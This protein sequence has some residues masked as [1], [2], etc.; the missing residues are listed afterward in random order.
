M[1]N[2]CFSNAVFC[3]CLSM[4]VLV[5]STGAHAAEITKAKGKSVLIKFDPAAEQL[6]V[7]EKHFALVDGKKKALIEITQ[8]KAGQALGKIL[9]GNAEASATLQLAAGAAAGETNSQRP[10]R[11]SR[12]SESPWSGISFGVL[13]GAGMDSQTVKVARTPTTSENVSLSGTG[14]GARLFADLPLMNQIGLFGRLGVEKFGGTGKSNIGS[15]KVDFTFLA[16][17]GLI[18]FDFMTGDWVPFAMA[19]ISMMY[20]ISQSTGG[21][22]KENTSFSTV[23]LGGAGFNWRLSDTMYAT[24]H[25]EYGYFLLQTEVTT[26]IIAAR[27]GIG[28]QF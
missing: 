2:K 9:K 20:P 15:E 28:L 3:V 23:A 4:A 22:L 6:A 10:Q 1:S 17:D 19:G 7:G 24:F 18:H 12:S 16:V 21:L 14:F 26:S 5:P 27:G 8:V 13:A 11:R 25:G